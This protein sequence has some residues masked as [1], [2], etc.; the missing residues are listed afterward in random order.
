MPVPID[1]RWYRTTRQLNPRVR[2][3]R[4]GEL[5]MANRITRGMSCQPD[6]LSAQATNRSRNPLNRHQVTERVVGTDPVRN[7]GAAIRSSLH[8]P[9]GEL[10]EGGFQIDFFFAKEG[11]GGSALNQCRGKIAVVFHIW[12][13]GYFNQLLFPD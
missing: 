12:F 5:N 4:G 13:Q 2:M 1:T 3:R 9:F 6:D 7:R 8:K 11:D 10:Q